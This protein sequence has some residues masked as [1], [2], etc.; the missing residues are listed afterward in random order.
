MQT[1][2]QQRGITFLGLIFTTIVL[3]FV[4]VVLAQVFPTLVEYRA[5]QAAANKAQEG[6]TESDIR[7]LFD[8]SVDVNDI[9]SVSGKDLD[10][11]KENE[12]VV[13]RFAYERQIHLMGPAYLLLKYSGQSK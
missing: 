4:G 8:K 9:K 11:S 1:K 7:N 5:I 3:A 6:E 12:K 13:V 10:I 2:S